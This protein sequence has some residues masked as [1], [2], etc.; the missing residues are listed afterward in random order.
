MMR[1]LLM[2]N[3]N[4]LL[5]YAIESGCST[6]GVMGC[7][8]CMDDTRA[9]HLQHGRKDLP[10]WST[11]LIRHNLDVM[12]IEKNVFDNIS[13]TV[14]DIKGKTKDVMKARKDLKIICNRPK[15][16]LD[17]RRP[18]VMRKAIMTTGAPPP[19]G[20]GRR[21]QGYGRGPPSPPGLSQRILHQLS[22]NRR[23][24]PSPRR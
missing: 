11:L 21:G 7:P 23:L 8:I 3:V 24:C 14:M 13:N 18:N 15:L 12:H 9:F 4:D 6:A 16:E 2:W 19:I 20:R 22:L 5:A 10:Y 1:A 17:E